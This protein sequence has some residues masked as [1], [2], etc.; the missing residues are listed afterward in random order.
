MRRF[1]KNLTIKPR[2]APVIPLLGNYPKDSASYHR[3]ICTA[4]LTVA[5]FTI[6]KK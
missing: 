1:L 3:N 6:A 5:L 2:F 4:I